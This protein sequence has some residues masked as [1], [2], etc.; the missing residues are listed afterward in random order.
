[1]ESGNAMRAETLMS[2]GKVEEGYIAIIG[3]EI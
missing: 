1:M 2:K 3:R